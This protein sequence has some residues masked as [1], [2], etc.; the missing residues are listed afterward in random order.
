VKTNLQVWTALLALTA[1]EVVLAYLRIPQEWMLFALVGISTIKAI[2]IAGWFMHMRF[3][4]ISLFL[5]L[6]PTLTVFVLLLFGF[7]P[8]ATRA[9]NM[10]PQ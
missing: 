8:D 10:R 6:I 9:L 1:L 7:L 3:E 5:A 2:L 4:R